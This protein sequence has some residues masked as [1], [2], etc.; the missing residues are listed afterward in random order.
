MSYVEMYIS[1]VV[2]TAL[3]DLV[4]IFI[5]K[6]LHKEYEHRMQMIHDSMVKERKLYEILSGQMNKRVRKAL[7]GARTNTEDDK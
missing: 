5:W 1:F 7:L 2:C 4:F 3:V 6:H